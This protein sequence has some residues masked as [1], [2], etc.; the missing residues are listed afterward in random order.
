M[1]KFSKILSVALLVALVLSLGVANA[2]AEEPAATATPKTHTI[3]NS[4]AGHTYEVYQI[5]RGDY[6]AETDQ[7]QNLVYGTNAKGEDGK[8][9][10]IEDIQK[11][12]DYVDA[13][14]TNALDQKDIAFVEQ[15]VTLSNP[16]A[17]LETGDTE[18]V[19][20]GYYLIKDVD[21]SL[22]GTN[23]QYTLYLINVLKDNITI[24]PKTS[25]TTHDKKVDDKNDSNTNEDGTTWQD[26]ADYDIGDYVPYQL[27]AHMA[28]NVNAFKKYHLTFTD[29]LEAGCFDAITTPVIKVNG[30][31]ISEVTGFNATVDYTTAATKTGFAVTITFTPIAPATLLPA[32]LNGKDVT[33]DFSAQ[34]GTGANIGQVGNVN[35]STLKYSNNPNSS[36]DHEE[37]ETPEDTVIVFT[38]DLVVNK[39]DQDKKPLTGATFS[40]YKKYVTVPTDKTE[41]TEIKYDSDKKTYEIPTDTHYVKVGTIAGTAASEFTFSGI[42]DG[43]YLLVEDVAPTGYNA[44]APQTFTV[45]ATHTTTAEVDKAT[46]KDAN[47]AYVL[48]SVSGAGNSITLAQHTKAADNTIDGVSTDIINQSGTQLPSTGGIG[49]TIF[50]VVG[51]V[52]VLAAIILLVTKKRMSE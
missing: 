11:L 13:G 16:V 8:P 15:F 31:E 33:I 43:E 23:E 39:Q 7:L 26:S 36:D 38:Y 32:E 47:G 5:F 21:N 18:T 22:D 48:T 1:K 45:T 19:A 30:V 2:F 49:T 41:A 44:I 14:S 12:A 34:L 3:T 46:K 6:D 51:G 25:T 17:T 20:E 35:T 9:V 10:S 4:T 52:L 27:T 42:D 40:L 50:Y 28:S 37:G 24:T 29:T